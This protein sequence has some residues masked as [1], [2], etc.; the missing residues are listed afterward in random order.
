MHT[1]LVVSTGSGEKVIECAWPAPDDHGSTRGTVLTGPVFTHFL[2]RFRAF[3]YEV[4]CWDGG[5]IPDLAH[6]V[7]SQIVID[8]VDNMKR[9][10][11][12]VAS[13]PAHRWGRD[14]L[15]VGDMWN[16]NSVISYVLARAGV[17]VD[18]LEPPPGTSSPGWTAGI[19]AAGMPGA[20]D[21]RPLS[22]RQ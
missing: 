14:E 1:A 9:V 10:V 22:S 20:W 6:A 18:D 3:R 11:A 7:A 13:V 4:R 12:E 2:G 15:S 21:Q 5:S 16:S 19:A 8:D 17:P